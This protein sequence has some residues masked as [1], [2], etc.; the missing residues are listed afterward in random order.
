M[1]S[2]LHTWTLTLIAFATGVAMLWAFGRCSDQT[3]IELAKRK[4]RAHLLAFRLF[5]DEPRLIFRAQRELLIW[6]GRYLAAML[7]P[8]LVMMLPLVA[9]LW[10]LDAVYGHRALAP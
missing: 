4:L 1:L 6:N 5:S 8:T 9:L 7:R 2:A 3:R 10:H